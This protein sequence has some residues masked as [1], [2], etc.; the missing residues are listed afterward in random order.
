VEGQDGA[1][2]AGGVARTH[3]R[4][5]RVGTDGSS[6]E[7]KVGDWT[8]DSYTIDTYS[9]ASTGSIPGYPDYNLLLGNLIT[10]ADQGVLY[11]WGGCNTNSCTSQFQLTSINEGGTATTV[12]TSMGINLNGVEPANPILPI[13]QRQDGTYVG[14]LVAP[15]HSMV[16]FDQ[17]GNEKWSV[18]GDS[19]QIATA[20][21]GVVGTSGT[22]YDSNGNATGPSGNANPNTASIIPVARTSAPHAADTSGSNRAAQ[23]Y[24]SGPVGNSLSAVQSWVSNVYQVVTGNVAQVSVPPVPLATP[25]NW[26]FAGANQ[27][28]NRTSSRCH[29]DRDD[30]I[31]QY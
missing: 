24:D 22:T 31:Y 2:W 7:I 13:L 23:A 16:A 4:I 28:G 9:G 20:D 12:G 21:N 18:P 30:L 14:E 25:P 6:L 10:N 17:Y 8:Q 1:I 15:Y 29:D 5:M 26:S 11:S 19:P 3:S 27:S